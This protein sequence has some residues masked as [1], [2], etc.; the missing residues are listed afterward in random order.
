MLDEYR[1]LCRE[2]ASIIPNW[3]SISKNDLCRE[4][5]K[6]EDDPTLRDAYYCAIMFKYWGAIQ[7]YYY[8]TNQLAYPEE[9]YNWLVRAVTYTL[10]HRKWE[11][12]TSSIYQDPDGP[13]KMINRSLKSARLTYYQYLNRY[14]RKEDFGLLSYEQL[15]EDYDTVNFDIVD[16]ANSVD[17]DKIDM[18]VYIKQIFLRKD[19]FLA[20]MLDCILHED[21]FAIGDNGLYSL[22]VKKLKK[23]LRNIDEVQAHLFSERYDIPFNEVLESLKYIPCSPNRMNQKIEANILNLRHEPFMKQLRNGGV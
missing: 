13:D 12:P 6:H 1:E 3:K 23:R 9:C 15:K 18:S 5:I 21:C 20:F 11:D 14:K 16:E 4:Y 10:K 2:K 8:A 7:H 22:D 17:L 19:Y